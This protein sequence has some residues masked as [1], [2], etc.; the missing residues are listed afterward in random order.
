[1][2]IN[3]HGPAVA[4]MIDGDTLP[5]RSNRQTEGVEC[6]SCHQLTEP[7]KPGG[8]ALQ[9]VYNANLA[10]GDIYYGPLK[11]P[12]GNAYHKS[13][14][15]AMW[16][17][18]EKLCATCHD[19]NYDRNGD[20]QIH[21][22]VDLVLQTTFDEYQSYRKGG[23]KSS[24][25]DCHMPVVPGLTN[26]ADGASVPFDRDYNGPPRVV[27]EHSF[28]GVDYP[29]DTV[30]KRDPQ[31]PKRQA[32]LANAAL[33][34]VEQS[35]QG[36]TL[37]L[38]F[39]IT[40]QTGH[41]LPT[42]FAF[43]RQMWI[44]L[45]VVE[46]GRTVFQSGVLAHPGDDLCDDGTFGEATNPLRPFVRGCSAV[47]TNLVNLQAK[48]VDKI[49]ALADASGNPVKDADGEFVLIQSKAGNETY[50]QHLTSGGVARTRPVDKANLGAIPPLG[51]KSFTY[52]IPIERGKTGTFTAR[53]LFRNL[54]PYWVRAMT[55]EP[56][57]GGAPKLDPLIDNIQTEEMA[58]KSGSFSH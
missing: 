29:L 21:K 58:R 46:N 3:C 10:R 19:V 33:F 45:V 49:A 44:E 47:D 4:T 20:G 48:L 52:K 12:I 38:K 9:G 51:S 28:V 22:A 15:V 24:C 31:K 35:T 25:M 7:V 50:L 41:N 6:T 26:A 13:D 30:K 11:G 39:T 40:N 37:A 14:K 53:L 1:M 8:G 42:G 43:A 57:P 56:A 34:D 32:L 55:A 27:H 16:D 54:P 2:C 36:N 23:G 5:L 18:P 17:E